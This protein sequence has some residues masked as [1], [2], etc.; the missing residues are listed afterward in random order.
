MNYIS[1]LCAAM[2]KF[3]L[4]IRPTRLARPLMGSTLVVL[5]MVLSASSCYCGNTK[6]NSDST[7]V[8]QPEERHLSLL[9]AGD[10]M[11]H[12][13]QIKAARQADGSYN[14]DEC[15]AGI[16]AEVERADVAIANFETTL[17]GPPYSGFPQFSA[18]DDFLRGVIGAG[19]DIML[20][21][22]NHCVDTHKK[23]L[24]R[25]LMMMDSLG[26][27]HIGTYRNAGERERNYPYLLEKN[28]L[29]IVLLNF[30]YGT[31][32]LPVPSP[33]HVNLMDTMEI[34][35]D[36]EKAR[37]MNPDAIIAFPH[38]GVEYQTLP[39]EAQRNM[40]EW[41]I[42]HGVSHIIGGHPH[43]AQ[44]LELRGEGNNLV[45]WSMGNVVSNQSKPN[46]YGGYMVRMDFTKRDSL[47]TLSDQSYSLYWVSRPPDN[48]NRHPYRILPIDYPDSLL[49][50]TEQRL[51]GSIR[52]SM[53]QL[54]ER[55]NV[56]NIRE[57]VI[58]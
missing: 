33:C 24:E 55:H 31:N 30:T 16:K 26:V 15:F 12:M 8:E 57:N 25:T 43:V 45:A 23:G 56:G 13:P 40:A 52:K 1:Y 7:S 19:F 46:T 2:K 42:R 48:G 9:I 51:R 27:P 39:S 36:I 34:A 29:R 44:P 11:Q 17:A 5:M 18:P 47:T 37:A 14:Y 4:H 50:P 41:L 38:W 22:N 35:A 53:R 28:G 32:G 49:T 58:Q 54:M 10:L 21:A 3:L 6:E 20:T